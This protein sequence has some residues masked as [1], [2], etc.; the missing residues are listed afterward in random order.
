VLINRRIIINPDSRHYDKITLAMGA[1]FHYNY[2]PS[3]YSILVENC[4]DFND[5]VHLASIQ[6]LRISALMYLNSRIKRVYYPFFNESRSNYD[7]YKRGSPEE[8]IYE[9]GFLLS[10]EFFREQDAVKFY[11][12]LNVV[13]GMWYGANFTIASPWGLLSTYNTRFRVSFSCLRDS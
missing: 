13:K 6:A 1:L 8:P 12:N 11:D 3:E 7:T 9:W 5:R 4:Q 10:I 2:N